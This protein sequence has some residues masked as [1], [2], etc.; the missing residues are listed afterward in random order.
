MPGNN[1]KEEEEG[2]QEAT[3]ESTTEADSNHK[4]E[5]EQKDEA[6]TQSTQKRKKSKATVDEEAQQDGK[7]DERDSTEGIPAHKKTKSKKQKAKDNPWI[8]SPSC[9]IEPSAFPGILFV[10]LEQRGE[11]GTMRV[12][13]QACG[14]HAPR[15]ARNYSSPVLRQVSGDKNSE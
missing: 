3:E 9:K 2:Q 6:G 13:S 10:S 12:V 11:E 14:S 15:L 1:N 5:T 7:I 4:E 8:P